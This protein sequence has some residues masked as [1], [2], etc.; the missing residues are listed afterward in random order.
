[1]PGIAEQRV[2]KSPHPV[3]FRA[4]V[5]YLNSPYWGGFKLY[6]LMLGVRGFFLLL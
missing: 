5:F 4:F 2:A 3:M 1:M 6:D